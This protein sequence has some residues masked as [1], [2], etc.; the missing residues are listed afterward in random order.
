M[1]WTSE[2]FTRSF[3]YADSPDLVNWSNVKLVQMWPNLSDT[4]GQTWAPEWFY[5]EDTE[6]Y[7]I[8]FS[9]HVNS[10]S[11]R[12]YYTKTTDFDTFTP[13][14]ELYH[15]VAESSVIDGFMAKVAANHYMMA[16]AQK[17]TIWIVD[18]D[19]PYGPWTER[20]S[21]AMP[22]PRE[23][24]AFFKIGNTWHLYAD[25]YS[26][27][28]D[29]VFRMATS[30]DTTNWTD[31]SAL[32]RFPA[33]VDIPDYAGPPHHGTIFAAP[34]ST[35]GAF[36]DEPQ[37]TLT[38]LSSL[39]YL[40]SFNDAAG[41]VS[42]GT[43]VTDTV[44]GVVATVRGVG[45]ELTGSGLLLPG[46]TT[47]DTAANSI[48]AYLDLPNGILS[49][50]TNLT[51][52]IWATPVS[53]RNWQRL[54][55]FG[56]T[57]QSG[58]GLPGEWT[59]APGT[60]APGN[61]SASDDLFWS[62]NNGGDIN[63]QRCEMLLNGASAATSDT[64][65]DTAPGTQYHY[66]FT[67]EDGVGYFGASG[68]RMSF[69][70]EGRKIGY[71]DIAFR[72]QEIEDVNNWLGRS[73]WSGDSNSNVE[74]DEVRIYSEALDAFDIYGHYL[75]GPDVP[76]EDEPRLNI[77]HSDAS[78]VV[79]WPGNAVGFS[80][81]QA[82]AFGASATWSAATNKIENTTNGLQVTFPADPDQTFFR[83]EK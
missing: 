79:N 13:P 49:A 34:L 16:T 31:Q 20:A 45:A 56:R 80:L 32:T 19:S 41:P 48:A 2:L 24:P 6:E 67:F 47:G 9:S 11:L 37:D 33:N 25:Y 3:G 64:A 83:L 29:D 65:M 15:D 27:V 76:V 51:V 63:S 35:L 69:Y 62:L 42:A 4:I 74:Y 66:V 58:N 59:G 21:A 44:S 30:L 71:R 14:I 61:T 43:T 46:D 26:G 36:L 5:L 75:A 52:E 7:M 55:D 53:P 23:G 38:N 39:V 50:L 73:Q 70:R 10:D 72:L 40:W 28:S 22:S 68:G 17:G 57:T 77:S 60:P 18:S 82:D 81:V 8:I 54:F 78:V 1:V 12:L